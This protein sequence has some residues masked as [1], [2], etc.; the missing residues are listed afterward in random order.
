[1]KVNYANDANI[2]NNDNK[3]IKINVMTEMTPQYLL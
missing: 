1:M 2:T 3:A